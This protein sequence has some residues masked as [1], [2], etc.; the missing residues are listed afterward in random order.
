M[1]STPCLFVV[2]TPLG[3]LADLSP[4][5]CA[6]L[7]SVDLIAAEDTRHSA[8]LLQHYG[9]GTRTLSLH[10]HNETE[11]IN[12]LLSVLAA[13]QSIALISD[14]GTPLVSDPGARLVSAVLAGGY[15]VSPLPGP[16]ALIS[17]LSVSGLPA[18][19][20]VFDGFL[21]AKAAKRGEVMS[22]WLHETRTTV[23][24]ETPH[25]ILACLQQ[26]LEICG[27]EREICLVREISKCYETVYRGS[28]VSVLQQLKRHPEQQRGE[29][30]LVVEGVLPVRTD[31]LSLADLHVLRCL[32]PAMSLKQAA[33]LAA[34][35]TGRGRR[36]FYQQ[37]L[38]WQTDGSA[39]TA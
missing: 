39:P 36:L 33:A 23:V 38:A 9:I 26:C 29:F 4:R 27:A 34:D 13:G 8:H 37:A 31:D 6:C 12:Q 2:A 30:V 7:G 35:I 25:R 3:N 21:P 5:A 22:R 10:A 15:R 24:Y 16:C 1:D 20:F 17:A 11:R 18:D 32:L 19:H 14:A 28:V